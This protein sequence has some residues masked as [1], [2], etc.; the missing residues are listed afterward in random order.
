MSGIVWITESDAIL[1]HERLLSLNGG[2][3]G[4]RDRGLLQSVL[5]RPQQLCNYGDNPTI[6]DLAASYI[7]GLVKNHS[8]VDGNKRVGFG[9][10]VLFLELNGY[11]FTANP[12]A[13]ANTI[14]AVA[15]GELDEAGLVLFLQGNSYTR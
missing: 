10:G 4:I 14:L 6:T 9:V 15:S 12:T 13:A 5:A 11:A 1:I 3:A 2:G 7:I 8:F